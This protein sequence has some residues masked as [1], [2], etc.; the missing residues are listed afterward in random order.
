MAK[1]RRIMP[2]TACPT[3]EAFAEY[4][5]AAFRSRLAEPHRKF[6]FA[7]QGAG[8]ISFAEMLTSA[9]KAPGAHLLGAELVRLY[10]QPCAQR[11]GSIATMLWPRRCHKAQRVMPTHRKS[12][13]SLT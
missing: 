4:G 2:L 13:I 8:L 1:G 11:R 3:A 5:V 6:L 12:L 9:R 7:E 10:V